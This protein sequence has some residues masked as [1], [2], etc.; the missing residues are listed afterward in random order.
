MCVQISCFATRQGGA[1]SPSSSSSSTVWFGVHSQHK[2]GCSGA[3]RSAPIFVIPA[4]H[5][6][7]GHFISRSSP[8]MSRIGVWTEWSGMPALQLE[9]FSPSS[10]S[11]SIGCITR[12]GTRERPGGWDGAGDITRSSWSWRAGSSCRG[13]GQR[14]DRRSPP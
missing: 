9:P 7:L 8:E 10:S 11:S 6:T 4:P 2:K 14:S 13:A 3:P 12:Q 5:T 1:N